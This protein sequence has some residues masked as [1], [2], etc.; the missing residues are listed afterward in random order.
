[1]MDIQQTF[2][3]KFVALFVAKA[4]AQVNKKAQ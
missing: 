4:I 3:N 2:A 1:M